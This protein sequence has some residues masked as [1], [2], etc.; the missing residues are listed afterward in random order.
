M[1]SGICELAHGVAQ[2]A[3]VLA[4]D[5]ARD[6]AGARVVGHQHQVAAGQ[7]D[8]GGERRALVAALLLVDLDH[9]LAALAE[10]RP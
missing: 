9:D 3:A 1:S 7:G 10:R 4:L 8:E 6:A 2:F 5:A